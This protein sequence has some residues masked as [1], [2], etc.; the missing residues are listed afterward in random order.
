MQKRFVGFCPTQNKEFSISMPYIN[1]QTM[2]DNR[3]V[4]VSGV[5]RCDFIARGG[6]CEIVASCPIIANAP[7]EIR[8]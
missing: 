5:P 2:S 1:S 3:A 4:Y 8:L 7:Q 6:K